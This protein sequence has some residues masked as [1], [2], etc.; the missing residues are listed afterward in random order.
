[1]SDAGIKRQME[2]E[3]ELHCLLTEQIAHQLNAGRGTSL[4]RLGL[5]WSDNMPDDDPHAELQ[6]V[7]DDGHEYVLDIE[8][9][10]TG[11]EGRSTPAA[12]SALSETGIE[13]HKQQRTDDYNPEFFGLNE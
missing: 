1:M 13:R 4:A 7:A 8:V 9:F 12:G 5:R 6:V 10:L 2:I 11:T 3:A